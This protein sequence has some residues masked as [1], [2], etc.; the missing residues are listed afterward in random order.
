MTCLPPQPKSQL[1]KTY[2]AHDVLVLPSVGDPFPFVSLEAMAC[3]LP[4]IAT[5]NCGTPLPDSSR[6]V[7]AMDLASLAKRIMQYA[8]DR[9]LV[10]EHGN[11]ALTFAAQFGPEK[12][13]RSIG[14]LFADILDNRKTFDPAK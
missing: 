2:E 5:E 9:L 13:R 11:E 12:Y 7:P 3:G 1:R 8:D 14:A 10:A 4:V 6:K